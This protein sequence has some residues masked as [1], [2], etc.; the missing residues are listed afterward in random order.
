MKSIK[1]V[2]LAGIL[3]FFLVLAHGCSQKTEEGGG[4]SYF[5]NGVGNTWTYS[6]DD[7]TSMTVTV[8]R[9]DVIFGNIA[10]QLFVATDLDSGGHVTDTDEEYYRVTDAG[11][12]DH[13]TPTYP[14]ETGL[15]W[16]LFPLTVGKTWTFVDGTTYDRIATVVAI[17]NVTVPA[18]T[19]SC[20][21]VS[22]TWKQ[23]D[24]EIS[25]DTSWFGDGVGVV[26]V[27]SSGSPEI[28]SVLESYN[29]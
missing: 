26:K 27:V 7:G 3:A 11:V 29:F 9:T 6:N 4:K 19:F 8:D 24:T 21:K 14:Q 2:F 16:L 18:G 20:Y 12:Y 25:T 15:P 17:E 22:Y 1:T 10:V 23:D 28:V 5:P 13:G